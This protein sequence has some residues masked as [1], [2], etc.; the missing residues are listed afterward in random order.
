MPVPQRL[1]QAIAPERALSPSQPFR[2]PGVYY[3]RVGI[4]FFQ[5]RFHVR[6][7]M[8]QDLFDPKHLASFL[9]HKDALAYG[10]LTLNCLPMSEGDRYAA[11]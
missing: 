3:P 2:I 8:E 4:R 6:L 11:Y 5:D 7:W 10:S 1:Y 9:T